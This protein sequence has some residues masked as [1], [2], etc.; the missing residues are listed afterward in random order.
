MAASTLG[1][2][3][4]D[5]RLKA[6]VEH[7]LNVIDTQSIEVI[8]IRDRR[9]PSR[10]RH[11]TDP[12]FVLFARGNI[13]LLERCTLAVV[14]ARHCT[15]YG[16]ETTRALTM[17]VARAGAVVVSGLAL[18]IDSVAHAAAL[19]VGGDTIAVLGS[20]ID[21]CYPRANR[22][23]F[24]QIAREGLLLS[25]FPPGAKPR[26][27]HFPQ[28]N[29]IIARLA[30]AVLVV[31]A[32]VNSGSL[33]TV[34]HAMDN[35]EILAVPGPIG[36]PTSE[37]TNLLISDGARIALSPDD[38][39][40][41]LGIGWVHTVEAEMPPPIRGQAKDVWLALTEEGRYLDQLAADLALPTTAVTQT[42]LELELAGLARQLP[43]NRFA[44]VV[45]SG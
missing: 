10:L 22:W 45:E 14:G 40:D 8:T 23:L 7:G 36:R 9:Y 5:D 19:E 27:Y 16:V 25:E 17:P 33:I 35:V 18:G 2:A 31:E 28:R 34:E 13:G 20:G 1:N 41:S 26:A 43:G 24:E 11:L 15:E 44:R 12:P 32:A 21:I 39:L 42:L 6:A 4:A 3:L 29:R 38:V 30:N 37:G